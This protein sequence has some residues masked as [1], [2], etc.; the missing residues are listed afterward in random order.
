MAPQASAVAARPPRTATRPLRRRAA[1]SARSRNDSGIELAAD[2]PVLRPSA[3]GSQCCARRQSRPRLGL[4]ET[5][6]LYD[7]TMPR[8]CCEGSRQLVSPAAVHAPRAARRRLHRRARPRIFV[9][10]CSLPCDPRA[11]GH[12]CNG[13]MIP[14]IRRAVWEPS[15]SKASTPSLD[16]RSHRD[17]AAIA[18]VH[19]CLE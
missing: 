9:V 11:G 2:H 16:A 7:Q 19:S 6:L 1:W 12:S 18:M 14:R 4:V 15:T 13:G 5:Q 17:T 10:R 3:A 8:A